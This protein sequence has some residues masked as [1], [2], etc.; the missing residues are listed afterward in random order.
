MEECGEPVQS[1]PG[2]LGVYLYG[3]VRFV[4]DPPGDPQEGRLAPAVV[5]EPDTLNAPENGSAKRGDLRL[6]H[7]ARFAVV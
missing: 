7:R 5:T 2:A 1:I 6:T 4:S 3:P